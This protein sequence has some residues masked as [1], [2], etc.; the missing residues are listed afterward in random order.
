SDPSQ[1]VLQTGQRGKQVA[2]RKGQ[3]R[4]LRLI[5]EGN[6]SDVYDGDTAAAV[7]GVQAEAGLRVDGKAGKQVRMLL[8]VW[9]GGEDMPRLR[10]KRGG[11]APAAPAPMEPVA[12]PST[13]AAAAPVAVSEAVAAPA[14]PAPA[15][16]AKPA[17][18]KV[19]AKPAPPKQA[20]AK[21]KPAETVAAVSPP[22][23]APP[24]ESPAPAPAPADMAPPTDAEADRRA[25]DT[26]LV[27]VKELSAPFVFE[28]LPP[29]PVDAE[30]EQTEPVAGSYPLV[31][32]RSS[33]A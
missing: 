23:P 4:A 25:G 15:P 17:A 12:E 18:P 10:G 31:P 13:P 27:E 5:A 33:P 3:L 24:V 9:T 14:A 28:P 21:P 19:A 32:R 2:T 1:P 7:A 20:P 26:A 16:A 22:K 30:K 11:E 29:G 8:T 6:S